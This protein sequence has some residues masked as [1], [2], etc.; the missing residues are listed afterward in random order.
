MTASVNNSATMWNIK[1]GCKKKNEV[2]I[3]LE[4]NPKDE[5]DEEKKKK[6]KR[7]TV[8]FVQNKDGRECVLAVD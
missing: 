1:Y 5:K 3:V 7:M 2:E 8:K 6:K 4:N